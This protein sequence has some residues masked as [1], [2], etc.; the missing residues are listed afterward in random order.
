MESAKAAATP[1]AAI[2]AYTSAV[3]EC[4]TALRI[5]SSVMGVLE[6]AVATT[7]RVEA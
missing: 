6:D 4:V 2:D 7:V 3:A 1:A 5:A